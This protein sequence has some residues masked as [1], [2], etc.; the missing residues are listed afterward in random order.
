VKRFWY[1]NPCPSPAR[2]GG[3]DRAGDGQGFEYQNRFTCI[4]AAL[5][6]RPARTTPR[7]FVHGCQTA[8]V[9]G[10]A[11]EEIFTDKYSR[12]KVQFHWDREGKKDANSSC[13]VR[14]ASTWAGRQWGAIHIPRIGQEVVVD[15]EEGDPDQPIV[16]GSVYNADNMPPYA[17]P[18]NKTQSGIKSR[19]SL[20]GGADN[21]NEIRF[22]DKKGSE[23]LFIHAEKNQDIEVENDETHWVGRDRTK[24]IDHDE[25]VSVGNN[26]TETVGKNETI[27]IGENR[28]ESVGKDESISV[29]GNQSLSVDKNRSIAVTG[30]QST[31]IDGSRSVGVDKDDALSVTKKRT[32]SIGTDDTLSV[33][34]KLVMEAGDEIVLKTGSATIA[35]KKDGTITISGKDITIKGS[36]KVNVKA[37]SDVIVKGSKVLAN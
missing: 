12:V 21:F 30:N 1:S 23:Q 32:V 19:S 36:G 28:T 6:Y 22:E 27:S 13:W 3:D 31:N 4:P 11:G 15:F 7:P 8:V 33:G 18:A 5:P 29:A 35:M 24:T 25:T 2:Q 34:K 20:G 26:R 9:V 37:S 10:P 14:V 17:L 16:I